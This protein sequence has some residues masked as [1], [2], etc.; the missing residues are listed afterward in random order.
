L[1]PAKGKI[2][3]ETPAS[4]QVFVPFTKEIV[5]FHGIK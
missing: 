5:R 4:I 1:H 2:E 3:K